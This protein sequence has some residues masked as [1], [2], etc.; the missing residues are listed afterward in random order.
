MILS[1]LFLAAAGLSSHAAFFTLSVS[2]EPSSKPGANGAVVV[3]FT[4][5][6][7]QVKLNQEPAPRL[8]LDET[9][10]LLVDRQPPPAARVVPADPTAARYLDTAQPVRFPV[11]LASGAPTGLHRIAATVTFF[12]CSKREGW[13]RKGSEPVELTVRVP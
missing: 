1:F 2:Y 7:E 5:R 10:K 13:C 4:P 6:D 11:A 9:Q 3:V 12:Y 8:K